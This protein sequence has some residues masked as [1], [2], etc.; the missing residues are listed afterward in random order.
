MSEKSARRNAATIQ[1]FENSEG[2]GGSA[3][4]KRIAADREIF[5]AGTLPIIG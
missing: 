5:P 3:P 4:A 2:F 1:Y